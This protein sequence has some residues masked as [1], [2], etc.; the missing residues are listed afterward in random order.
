MSTSTKQ[1][2]SPVFVREGAWAGGRPGA[3]EGR[4]GLTTGHR[5]SQAE[6]G[7]PSKRTILLQ[8]SFP[9][10][11]NGPCSQEFE[12]KVSPFVGVLTATQSPP[13]LPAHPW[14]GAVHWQRH[15]QGLLQEFGSLGPD[16]KLSPLPTETFNRA[17]TA[18][19]EGSS[20]KPPSWQS[21]REQRRPD[22]WSGSY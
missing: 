8:C 21:Q 14:S 10:S 17:L 7:L 15:R 12:V 16:G 6:T 13:C 18:P 22:R 3:L 1:I 5:V 4:C 2:V 20:C 9:G 19:N 11:K